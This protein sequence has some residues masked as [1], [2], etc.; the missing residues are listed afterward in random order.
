MSFST[1]Y[2][3]WNAQRP[4][5]IEI[6]AAA[7]CLAIGAG[8][9]PVL[10]FYAGAATLGKYDGASLEKLFS[11]IYDGLGRS[12]LPAWTVL[13]GPYAL[14]LLFKVLRWWWRLGTR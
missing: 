6:A 8:L 14:Y 1:T 13:L 3:D 10:I 11:S 5:A 4:W 12:S 2:R 7:F 9:M